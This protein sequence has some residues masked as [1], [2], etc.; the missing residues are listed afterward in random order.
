MEN[1]KLIDSLY[2]EIYSKCIEK[3]FLYNNEENV[4]IF[5]DIISVCNKCRE[6]LN[7]NKMENILQ[8]DI[9]VNSNN[10][11]E[12]IKKAYHFDKSK[13]IKRVCFDNWN[14][15]ENIYE[16]LLKF[17]VDDYLVNEIDGEFVLNVYN[18]F[19][20]ILNKDIKFD[21]LYN[22]LYGVY[23]KYKLDVII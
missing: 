14:I 2:D 23:I 19:I 9:Q 13:E 5:K 6:K 1:I 3:Y 17:R 16:N 15:D 10:L 20:E 21:A 7:I 18:E 4:E 12:V 22:L 8:E 11:T